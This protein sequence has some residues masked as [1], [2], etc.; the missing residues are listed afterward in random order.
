MCV[1]IWEIY[2]NFEVKI[3]KKQVNDFVYFSVHVILI[4][5][6][7]KI[8]SKA[9]AKYR[10]LIPVCNNEA[11]TLVLWKSVSETSTNIY[12][13]ACWV[14]ANDHSKL[15]KRVMANGCS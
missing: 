12:M 2:L 5:Q 10:S 3:S 4:E 14:M 15:P 1:V 9:Y 6:R 13:Y 7:M 8:R 11:L